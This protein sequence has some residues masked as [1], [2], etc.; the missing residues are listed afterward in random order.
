MADAFWR[1]QEALM[2]IGGIVTVADRSGGRLEARMP[3]T[4]RSWGEWVQVDVSGADGNV[5]LRIRSASRWRTTLIDWGKNADNLQ[6]FLG[7]FAT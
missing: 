2:L 7:C 1:S 3:M 6:R 5:L 4:F